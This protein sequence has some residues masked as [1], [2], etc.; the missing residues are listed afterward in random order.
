MSGGSKRVIFGV[1]LFVL[2]VAAI[3][4][5]LV[6]FAIYAVTRPDEITPFIYD[7]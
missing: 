6:A 7:L 2:A 3:L 5:V 1:T 4:M